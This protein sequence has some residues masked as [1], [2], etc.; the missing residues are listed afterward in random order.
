MFCFKLPRWKFRS[1]GRWL[2]WGPISASLAMVSANAQPIPKITSV[3]PEWLQRGTTV[4]ITLTGE[5][6]AN[7][8][9]FIISGE[10]GLS[11]TPT[12]SQAPVVNVEASKGGISAIDVRDNKTV[13]ARIT[14][15]GEAA[16]GERELRV[17]TPAGVSNPLP[18]HVGNLPEILENQPNNSLE[19][20]QRVELPV[21][22]TGRINGAAEIDYYRFAGKRG[23]NLIVD[24]YASRLGTPM[25]PSLAILDGSGKEL[26]RSEDVNGL[27]SLLAFE[28]PQDGE[29][30]LRI[31][32]FR[33]QGGDTFRYRVLAG[34]MPY[35]YSVF[36]FGARR[37]Q[38]VEVEVRG[39][40]FD[41]PKLM[42][43]ID[44]NAPLGRQD[45]RAH[46]SAGIS[47]PFP[48]DVTDL[49]EVVESEPNSA[50]DQADEVSLPTVINGRISGE[51]DY[52]A[53]K[54][55]VEKDQRFIFEVL[56]NRFGSALD[57]L[58]TLTDDKGNVL[59]RNDDA[60]GADARIERKFTEAGEYVILV[61]DLLGRN[62]DN[63]GY[64][65]TVRRPQP[66]FFVQFLPDNP[67]IHRGGHTPVRCE[68]TRLVG[69]NGTVRVAFTDLPP[70]LFSEPLLL[71]PNGPPSGLLILSAA[72]DCPLS[73]VPLKL[74]ATSVIGGK[75]IS[76]IVEPLSNDKPVKEG[77]LT[78]LDEPPFS[79]DLASLNA[80]LEQDQNANVEV[81]VQRQPGFTG[82][83]KLTADGFSAG[84][85]P[86]TKSFE[87]QPASLKGG[88]FQSTIKLKAKLDS[89]VG[90]RPVLIKGE[91]SIDGQTV[92]QY[93]STLPM[94]VQEVPFVLSTTLKRLSVTA[95]PSA[96]QSAAREA[97]FLVKVGR[98]MGFT[99]E[100][101]L[102]M[103]GV[104]DGITA[105]IEKI[106]ANGG[107]SP[108]KLVA[109][110]KAPVGKE[111]TLQIQGIGQFNDRNYKQR[112]GEI[113]LTVNPPE[114]T[115]TVATV[116][117]K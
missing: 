101:A 98:R 71:T 107:E 59:E 80:A 35:V 13:R 113:K 57:A 23:Q 74:T 112:V 14:L 30:V 38:N 49:P 39:H 70:G 62:G 31:R 76:R 115:A 97:V 65:L 33:Y 11:S 68:L 84:R 43:H 7:L 20:A 53:F 44:G 3:S 21:A 41:A 56:A 82:E 8:S 51:K 29:Y 116:G 60:I 37:G 32:D 10:P 52:D 63:F 4:E 64:R 85:D 73:P 78:V 27:D 54:F 110:E 117:A 79:V 18:L 100:I 88:E 75:T 36:P 15:T 48:F 105:V 42:L 17:A 9:R 104:P 2:W 108:V 25:D 61:E 26:A 55:K 77:F 81:V 103:E 1:I 86:I 99:N 45:I 94:T 34:A 96:S 19:Q 106:P 93:T 22:I 114:D 58:L 47:N 5:N 95:L 6:L 12:S 24:V 90:T 40:N 91:A 83:I 28:I 46:T 111:F 92:T 66:D 16:L 89:E 67:R 50:I 69:F 109:S 102:T 72:K 87:V